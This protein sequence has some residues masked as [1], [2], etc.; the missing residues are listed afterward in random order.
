M[1]KKICIIFSLFLSCLFSIS[2]V[3]ASSVDLNDMV[4]NAYINEDGSAHIQEIWDM[5]VNEGTEV[6]KVFDNMGASQISNLQ[7]KDENG[8]VYRNIGEWDVNA[9]RTEKN[10]KCGLVTKADGYELCF[11]VGEYGNRTYTFEYDVSYFVNQYT[12]DQG[13][14]YA[15]FSEMELEPRQAKITLSSP[16]IAFVND[17]FP[18]FGR[19][20]IEKRISS[21]SNSSSTKSRFLM[22]SSNKSP[23]PIP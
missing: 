2:P 19:P 22:I 23:I 14:N 8:L 5:N 16:R 6:Y 20:I 13:I 10:G 21:S 15:F 4:V 17:D 12:N 3:A 9:S 18:T 11:G 7:V 1:K